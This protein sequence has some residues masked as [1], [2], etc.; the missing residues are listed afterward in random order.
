ML[1]LTRRDGETIVIG[2]YIGDTWAP[3]IE[4]QVVAIQGDS[5]SLGIKAPKAI[6][7]DR[8][9]IRERRDKAPE[10]EQARQW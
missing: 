9:E 2:G 8:S 3:P 10:S 1:V 7:V 5:V 6:R 4:V